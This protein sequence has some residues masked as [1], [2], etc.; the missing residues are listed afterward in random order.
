MM[1]FP[2]LN[3]NSENRVVSFVVNNYLFCCK[4]SVM[5]VFMFMCLLDVGQAN[6]RGSDRVCVCD[7]MFV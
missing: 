3:E 1:A 6:M 5:L 2:R 7:G 4:H